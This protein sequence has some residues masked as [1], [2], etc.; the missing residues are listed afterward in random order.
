[1]RMSTDPLVT[2]SVI[3]VIA[4]GIRRWRTRRAMKSWR[5]EHPDEILETFN[6]DEVRMKTWLQ[7]RTIQGLVASG[8]AAVL[9]WFL[10]DPDAGTL[11]AQL[12]EWLLQGAQLGGLIY[13][14]R[15]RKLAGGPLA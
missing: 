14:A 7:S 12:A 2:W 4:K 9:G 1:M 11:G 8:S 13:A 3:K 10:L 6:A 15:G 5:A